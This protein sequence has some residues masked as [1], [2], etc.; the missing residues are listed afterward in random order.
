[1]ASPVADQRGEASKRWAASALAA[2]R[3]T[4]ATAIAVRRCR[5]CIGT[6]RGG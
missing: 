2:V 6:S 3:V 5:M 1:M 4:A